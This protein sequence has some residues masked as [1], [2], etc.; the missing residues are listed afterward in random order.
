MHA[1]LAL[2][3]LGFVAAQAPQPCVTPKQWEANF[4]EANEQRG[5]TIRGRLSYDA[6]Y[7]RERIIEQFNVGQQERAFEIIVLYD[8]NIEYV[9]DFSTRNCTHRALSRTW[10][11]FG[12]PPNARSVGEAY[13]GSSAVLSGNILTS[14]WYVGSFAFVSNSNSIFV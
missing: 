13:I 14:L 3:L 2:C 9:Y 1:I 7:H 10:R 4:F 6:V 8:L 11:D 12:I 5:F